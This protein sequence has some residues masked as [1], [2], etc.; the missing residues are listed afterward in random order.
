MFEVNFYQN[1]S[2]IDP[3]KLAS[4]VIL[5]ELNSFESFSAAF[6]KYRSGTQAPNLDETFFSNCRVTCL[7]VCGV[8]LFV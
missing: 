6:N 5:S 8:F 2:A 7:N 1:V 4:T 3:R